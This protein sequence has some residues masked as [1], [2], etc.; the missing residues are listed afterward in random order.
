MARMPGRRGNS[1]SKVEEQEEEEEVE[2]E[3]EEGWTTTWRDKTDG[4][5]RP[6]GSDPRTPQALGKH[7]AGRVTRRLCWCETA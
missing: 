2:E 7:P 3:E 4:G 6:R 5:R 1:G